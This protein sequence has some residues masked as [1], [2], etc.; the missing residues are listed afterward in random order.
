MNGHNN[1]YIQTD[2]TY[3][4]INNQELIIIGQ[5][6]SHYVNHQQLYNPHIIPIN[7]CGL[8]NINYI[9]NVTSSLSTNTLSHNY[10]SSQQ[11][12]D[13]PSKVQ[14]QSDQTCTNDISN[15]HYYQH[16]NVTLNQTNLN[17][18]NTM[19]QN[20]NHQAPNTHITDAIPTIDPAV[21]EILINLTQN[22]TINNMNN[23]TNNLTPSNNNLS[24]QNSQ[25]QSQNTAETTNP[26]KNNHNTNLVTLVPIQLQYNKHSNFQNNGS[27]LNNQYINNHQNLIP[28]S[29]PTY[30]PHANM[31]NMNPNHCNLST[32]NSVVDMTAYESQNVTTPT[33]P[34]LEIVP[35]ITIDPPP[36]Q[37]APIPVHTVSAAPIPTPLAI[38]T[39]PMPSNAPILLHPPSESLHSMNQNMDAGSN[40]VTIGINI[41]CISSVTLI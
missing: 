29:F 10:N 16:S 7:N 21:S 6:P 25:F 28:P 8:N 23:Y 33:L 35:C 13:Q 3:N 37:P 19:N 11:N 5:N 4:K 30:Y 40:I 18:N 1:G 20:N 2:D 39:L 24:Q 38:P 32:H 31:N 26:S 9:N 12:I 34:A 36:M 41:F 22:K 14:P 15:N 17:S 27:Y